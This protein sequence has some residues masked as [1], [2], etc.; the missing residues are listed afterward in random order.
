MKL[1]YAQSLQDLHIEV[2]K[3]IREFKVGWNRI[4]LSKLKKEY[5]RQG[6]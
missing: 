5:V 3:T 2:L 4:D 1:N 6:S